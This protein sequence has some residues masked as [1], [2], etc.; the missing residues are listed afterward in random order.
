ML[1][2]MMLYAFENGKLASFSN[3]PKAKITVM[4]HALPIL[5]NTG[6]TINFIYSEMFKQM[7]DIKLK[8]TKVSSEFERGI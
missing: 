5:V 8:P 2:A 3:C 7:K 6:A 1:Q 4:G